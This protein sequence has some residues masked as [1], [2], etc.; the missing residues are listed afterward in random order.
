MAASFL[1]PKIRL[2]IGDVVLHPTTRFK[3]LLIKEESGGNWLVEWFAN[4]DWDIL[5]RSLRTNEPGRALHLL[6]KSEAA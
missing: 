5:K 4:K 6:M 1:R 2:E 3:G